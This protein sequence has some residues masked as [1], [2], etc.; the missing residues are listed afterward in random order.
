VEAALRET[1]IMTRAINAFGLWVT[2]FLACDM[3]INTTSSLGTWFVCASIAT[4]LL[5]CAYAAPRE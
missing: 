3:A 2:S 1:H 5:G 4:G